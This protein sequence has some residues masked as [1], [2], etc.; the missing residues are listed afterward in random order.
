MEIHFLEA[1]TGDAFVVDCGNNRFLID[2]G[3]RGVSKTIQRMLRKDSSKLLKGIFVSHV[4]RDHVGG[5]VKLFEHHHDLIPKD[6]PIYMNHPSLVPVKQNDTGL[7]TYQDG[8]DLK[9]LLDSSGYITKG[10]TSKE[11]LT[12]DDVEIDILTPSDI[13]HTSL[14]LSWVE[15]DEGLVSGGIIDVDYTME[16]KEPKHTSSNDIVNS[17]SISFILSFQ[18]KR[19]LFLSDSLPEDINKSLSSKQA[20]DVIKVSHHGSKHNTSM[21]LLEKIDCNSYIIS[22]NGP[23]SY[24]HPHAETIVRI[25]R[26][27]VSHG[28]SECNIH[29]NYKKVID[30]I[31]IRN[32]PSG[33]KVNLTHTKTLS[34]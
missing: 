14:M 11:V 18:G 29:F 4:D 19:A 17:S 32:L 22:T 34:I 15:H 24:G 6:V 23:S 7:V 12:F 26:S 8:N 16:L 3:T 21:A 10:V 20:F 33:I 2:G 28:Y 25:I 1:K 27:C 31:K 13:L 30:R 9:S 5:I